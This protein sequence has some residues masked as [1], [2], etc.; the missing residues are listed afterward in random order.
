MN[1][2]PA[3]EKFSLIFEHMCEKKWLQLSSQFIN[4]NLCSHVEAVSIFLYM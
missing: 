3:Q 1:D 2:N 4:M